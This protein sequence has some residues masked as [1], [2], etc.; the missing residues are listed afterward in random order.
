MKALHLVSFGTC[1]DVED[2]PCDCARPVLWRRVDDDVEGARPI[3]GRVLVAVPN[4]CRHVQLEL[5]R[6]QREKLRN[7]K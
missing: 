2:L 6:L 7:K 5:E 3:G 4:G 1:C